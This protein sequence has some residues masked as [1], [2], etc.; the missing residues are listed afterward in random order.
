LSMAITGQ[1][2]LHLA[3]ADFFTTTAQATLSFLASPP[4]RLNLVEQLSLP[5]VNLIRVSSS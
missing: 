2:L 1:S 3:R 5:Q 4:R